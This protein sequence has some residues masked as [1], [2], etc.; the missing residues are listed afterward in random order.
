MIRY[1]ILISVI[2]IGF[3]SC[4]SEVQCDQ[5]PKTSANEDELGIQINQIEDYLESEGI[6]YQTHSSGIR[7]SI[8]ENGKGNSPN[9]CS[10]VS[11]DYEGRVLGTDEVFI[12]GIGSDISLRASQV[13]PGFKMAITLMN[14][15]ADYRVF[16]PGSLL[17]NKG[18]TDVIPRNIP[19]GENIEFRI[20]VNR[21]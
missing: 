21:Y 7:Y 20:R 6:E 14:K 8:I 15:G 1:L 2:F 4:Q 16:I 17:I 9:Y 18:V 19:D 10:V 3:I 12:S 5:P 11:I 13:V